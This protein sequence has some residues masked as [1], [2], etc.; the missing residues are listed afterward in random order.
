MG[1]NSLRLTELIRTNH[2]MG[3]SR[4]YL[5]AAKQRFNVSIESVVTSLSNIQLALNNSRDA[6]D[7]SALSLDGLVAFIMSIN[8][9]TPC[10]FL[11]R[12]YEN[13]VIGSFCEDVFS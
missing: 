9:Y 12:G 8:R 10:G 1:N 3:Q 7:A 11:G 2:Q 5:E 13:V 4:N 6:I